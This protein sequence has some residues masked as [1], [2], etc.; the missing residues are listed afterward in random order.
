MVVILTKRR[1]FILSS[2]VLSAGMLLL[3]SGF[4]P[5]RYLAIGILCLISIPLT[6]WSLKEALKG[7]IWAMCWMLPLLFTAGVC[8]FY[9]LLPTSL[10]VGLPVIIFYLLGIYVVFLSENIFSVAAIRTIQLYRSSMAVSFL[11]SLVISFLLYDTV[12]SFRLPFYVNGL[13]FWLVS[14]LIFLHGCWA[15]TLEEKI[16]SRLLLYSLVLSL[17]IGEIGMAISFWPVSVTL[18]SVF[19]TSVVYVCLGLAQ[20][21]LSDRLFKSTIR[22]YLAV[23]V[24]VFFVLLF[25]TSWG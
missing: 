5:D 18:G 22:E 21:K 17:G 4:F 2:L 15:A 1:K 16:G 23:G 12:F 25:Y 24:A 11:L 8:F 19:L 6:L 9:F 13:V 10:Y 7:P 3:Q 20:A 14:F